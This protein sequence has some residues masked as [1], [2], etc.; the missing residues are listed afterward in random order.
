MGFGILRYLD[1]VGAEYGTLAQTVRVLYLLHLNT[2]RYVFLLRFSLIRYCDYRG[3]SRS[4]T[5]R[6]TTTASLFNSAG[7]FGCARESTLIHRSALDVWAGSTAASRQRE[8]R[9][10][11]MATK[12]RRK[13]EGE[14]RKA[15]ENLPALHL[16]QRSVEYIPVGQYGRYVHI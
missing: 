13:K 11:C 6:S 15:V 9:T 1:E 16:Q 10:S 2:R 5:A 3:L 14:E 8:L 4:E 7:I 12:R